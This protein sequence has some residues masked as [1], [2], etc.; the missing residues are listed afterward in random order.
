LNWTTTDSGRPPGWLQSTFPNLYGITHKPVP[1]KALEGAGPTTATGSSVKC[2]LALNGITGS[3]AFTLGGWSANNHP[4]MTSGL[5]VTRQS[6]IDSMF[7][8]A[9]GLGAGASLHFR[10]LQYLPIHV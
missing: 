5:P 3:S 10:F 2:K 4:G 6:I 9:L 1:S 8:T 7:N